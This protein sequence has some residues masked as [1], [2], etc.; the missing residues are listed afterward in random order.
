MEILFPHLKWSVFLHRCNVWEHRY[1]SD[2]SFS[3]FQ[4]YTGKADSEWKRDVLGNLVIAVI[5]PAKEY[6]GS[7]PFK[8]RIM[9]DVLKQNPPLAVCIS[10]KTAHILGKINWRVSVLWNIG[11]SFL[12]IAL[13]LRLCSSVWLA[14]LD[15][16]KLLYNSEFNSI[17]RFECAKF[18]L[19]ML[20]LSL[21][22]N[23]TNAARM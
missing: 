20:V 19:E 9:L 7:E 10:C 23:V 12:I 3:P 21:T 6:S 16:F 14:N 11:A 5:I 2:V 13:S 4:F 1:L 8:I 18:S 22:S 15:L 17:S